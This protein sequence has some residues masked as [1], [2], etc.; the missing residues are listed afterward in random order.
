MEGEG[1]V[2]ELVLVSKKLYKSKI[3]IKVHF[4]KSSAFQLSLGT[5]Q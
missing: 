4:L 5:F 3:I 2:P 1:L